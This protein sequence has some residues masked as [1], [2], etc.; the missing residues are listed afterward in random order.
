MGP[1]GRVRWIY[2]AGTFT[3]GLAVAI[4]FAY[5]LGSWL[6]A[7]LASGSVFSVL[8]VLLAI[9]GGFYNLYRYMQHR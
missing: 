4:V 9:A 3:L 1:P 2:A 7:R 6:D 8:L 5:Y